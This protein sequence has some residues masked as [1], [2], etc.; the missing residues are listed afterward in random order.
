[1]GSVLDIP[2]TLA[3]GWVTY[4]RRVIPNVNPDPW[5]VG[6]A[7]ASLA[8]VTVGSH[9]FLRWLAGGAWPWTRSLKCVT[10]VLLMF[11]AGIAMVGVT[12]QA[13]WLARSPEP[14]VSDGRKMHARI[15]SSNNL[16]Q[17][18]LAAHDNEDRAGTLPQST[19]DAA[20]R[21]MH[22]WQTAL[23]PWLEQD[24][25]YKRIDR[26]QPWTHP[27]NA[28]PLGTPV[29]SFLNP[30][31]PDDRVNG[32]GVSHYACNPAVVMG[33]A[34]KL[35]DFQKGSE[36]TILAGEVNAGF[37]AWGDPLNVRDPRAGT[38][39]GPH[40]Y[41]T[42]GKR[43]PQFLMLDGSVRAFDP[44]ELAEFTDRPPE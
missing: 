37:R 40:A 11:V 4:L 17:I 3:F 23:L 39:G 34:K 27:A 12:H 44:K 16:K 2:A 38:G 33:R 5:A 28:E 19:F 36:N 14:L 7:V 41:G 30:A 15:I 42:A 29:K 1:M 26:T 6:T 9:Y 43:P 10:L 32:F 21:P 18:G 22:S 13:A 24:E 8:G 35:S 20:G 31:M 25:T